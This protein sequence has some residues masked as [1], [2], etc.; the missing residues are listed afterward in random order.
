MARTKDTGDL[1]ETSLSA[2]T[3]LIHGGTERSRFDET[4]EP[5]YTTSG[6]VYGSAEE[7]ESAFANDGSRYVYSRFRNPTVWAFEQR[8]ADYEGAARCWGTASGMAAVFSALM[9]L[10]QKG[11]RLVAPHAMFGSCLWIVKELAPKY[12]VETVLV[13]GTDL[14]QWQAALARPTKAVFLETPTNPMLEVIDLA[15]VTSLAHAAGARVIVDNVFA[16]PVLQK[17]LALG[18]DVV[19]YSATKHIDGQG[20]CMGGAILTSDPGYSDLIGPFLRHTGPA[21]A[22]FNAWLLLKGMETL[23]MR[24]AAH[25]ANALALARHLESHPHLARVIYPGLPSHPQAELARRQMH[26][27]GPLIAFDLNGGKPE[28]YRFMNALNLILISNNLG[29]AKSLITHPATTTHQRLSDAERA[30]VGI[31]PGSLRLSVGLEDP[32]DLIADLEQALATL[33]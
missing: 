4:C 18:A 3:R 10:L 12:G 24:V 1:R 16:T 33:A 8:L 20:R 25:A 9:C 2:R 27:G 28:A 29:D 31:G 5:I 17:P 30:R 22:P 23:E 6:Y 15:A 19:I 7:A 14:D 26:S 13:E 11:D 21:M 32:H